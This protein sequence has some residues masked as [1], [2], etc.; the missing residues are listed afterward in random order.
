MDIVFGIIIGLFVLMLLVV[1]HE[2]GHFWAARKSGIEVEEFAIG[3]SPRAIAWQ[4]KGGKWQKIKKE[5]WKKPKGKGL[6]ISLNWLPIGG[7]CKMKG[8]SDADV[9]RG[10]FGASNLWGKTKT[11]FGGVAAN[12]V[13]AAVIFTILAWTGMPHFVEGQFSVES[14]TTIEARPV[15]I[16]RVVEGSPAEG[17]KLEEGDELVAMYVESGCE[18][19]KQPGCEGAEEDKIDVIV[20]GDVTSF[21]ERNAGGLIGLTYERDGELR[22]VLVQLN[23]TGSEYLLGVTMSQEGAPLYRS[24]WSAPVVGVV[25]TVQLTGETF[26]GV[27]QL[28]WNL[29][30]GIAMQV[31]FDSEVR[32]SGAENLE[33]AGNA[34]S[35]PVGIIGYIFPAF[36]SSGISNLAF[37]TA[38]IS[39]S[40]ACMNLLPIPAL[41]G[42]RWLLIVIYRLRRKKLTT[43]IEEKIV[44]RAF[45]VLIGLI[46]II[47]V[48]DITRF[49][50]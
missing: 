38:I 4:K 49:F 27:G 44:G 23:E 16:S 20:P 3:F 19:P 39:I 9:R 45:M 42:G 12:L 30:S 50:R 11:L 7:F 29:V 32:D 15:I 33:Q 34:V 14:D 40:L 21:N 36:A 35:G 8:E 48:L 22:N 18:S 28:L 31:N 25:T 5:D 24:T 47:T 1:I 41:D 43:E 13:A 37:L 2:L 17:A 26:R 46:V 10:S 6:I